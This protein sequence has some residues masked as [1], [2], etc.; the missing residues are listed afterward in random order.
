[1]LLE[2]AGGVR[3]AGEDSGVDTE[4]REEER[5]LVVQ[6]GDLKCQRRW[7][8]EEEVIAEREWGEGEEEVGDSG[9]GGQPGG[10]AAED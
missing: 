6:P 1:M 2:D 10:V 5:G 9:G 8:R 3:G 4:E 7:R